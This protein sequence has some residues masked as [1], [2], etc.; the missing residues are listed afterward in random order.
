M[1]HNSWDSSLGF[2]RVA[3]SS[4]NAINSDI[5]KRRSFVAPLFNAGYLYVDAVEK[6]KMKKL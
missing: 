1:Q 4:N 5:E 2:L 3:A 6:L